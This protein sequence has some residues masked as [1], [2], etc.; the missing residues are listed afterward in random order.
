MT[1]K[2]LESKFK[3]A[4]LGTPDNE[5]DLVIADLTGRYLWL[6]IRYI[7]S[8]GSYIKTLTIKQKDWLY[9]RCCEVQ[10]DPFENLDVWAREHF[11]TTIIT[12]AYTVWSIIKSPEQ[13]NCIF[14]FTKPIARKMLKKIKT[15]LEQNTAYYTY[16]PDIFWEEPEK[17]AWRQSKNWSLEKGL[18]IKRKGNP[19]ESTLEAWGLIDGQPTSTHFDNL[20]YDDVVTID[21]VRTPEGVKKC[22]E[23]WEMSLNCGKDGGTSRYVGTFYAYADPYKVMLD[24]GGV[25]LRKYS[26]TDD[27]TI[28]GKSVF[29]SA[30]YLKKKK[31]NMGSFTFACQVLCD[32]KEGASV[33]FREEWL[34]YWVP[35]KYHNM[36]I[37]IIIDPAGKKKKASDYTVMSVIGVGADKN[38]YLIDMIR[39]KLSLTEKAETLF[40][41]HQKY[42]PIKVIYEEYGLQADIEHIQY[43]QKLHN[44]RFPITP[45]GGRTA[46][47]DRIR[48]LEPLFREGRLYIPEHLE[49]INYEKKL[50]DVMQEFISDEYL[51]FPFS[52][53]D[54][55]LDCIARIV[56]PEITVIFPE[57]FQYGDTLIEKED[58]EDYDPF[59][60]M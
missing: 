45:I 6:F 47:E 12:E 53:H 8:T 9:D 51:M 54:D 14:S 4:L 50:V 30:E 31:Q 38:Y 19:K 42:N 46:K 40:R 52:I 7:M 21:T 24:R 43:V 1:R 60:N 11:K 3:R 10:A 26:A 44:Y 48:R 59:E 17:E 16:W 18:T 39:D 25:K 35:T 49:K 28:N 23:A 2:R 33:G 5:K 56:D 20:I 29:Y 55:A 13:T 36:N 27:G 34:Q 32:P 41:L 15:E 58:D 57:S 22:V 37:Y